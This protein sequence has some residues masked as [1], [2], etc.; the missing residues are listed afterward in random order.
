M[1]QWAICKSD[2]QYHKTNYKYE[3]WKPKLEL[4][5][6]IFQVHSHVVFF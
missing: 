5:E 3:R 6:K 2:R 4:T 1:F